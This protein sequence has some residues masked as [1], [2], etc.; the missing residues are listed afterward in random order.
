[1]KWDSR[2]R[3]PRTWLETA[4]IVLAVIAG[5]AFI[6]YTLKQAYGL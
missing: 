5:Y 4:L 2:P 1:M 6:G 3:K